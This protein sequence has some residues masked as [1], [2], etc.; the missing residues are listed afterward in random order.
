ML[1]LRRILSRPRTRHRTPRHK[2]RPMQPHGPRGAHSVPQGPAPE[3]PSWRDPARLRARLPLRG[4]R[5]EVSLLG[6]L[7]TRGPYGRGGGWTVEWKG[8]GSSPSREHTGRQLGSQI[9]KLF[10]PN[11]SPGFSGKSSHP[12]SAPSPPRAGP[13]ARL[14]N[15]AMTP[16]CENHCG[17][18]RPAE[19]RAFAE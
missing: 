19:F 1:S 14:M 13:S 6:R 12:S 17:S 10:P 3:A 16:N 18:L 7:P 8:P 9:R 11:R 5:S 15:N 2:P 4:A